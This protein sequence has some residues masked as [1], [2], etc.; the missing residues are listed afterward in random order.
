MALRALTERQLTVISTA[1]SGFQAIRSPGKRRFP[2]FR[3][4]DGRKTMSGLHDRLITSSWPN[5]PSIK[6]TTPEDGQMPIVSSPKAHD[7]RKCH[8]SPTI[9]TF[10]LKRLAGAKSY[11]T[12][13]TIP[14]HEFEDQSHPGAINVGNIAALAMEQ[15][16]ATQ[17]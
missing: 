7:W 13:S 16:W 5:V 17:P 15:R 12:S 1:R 6:S 11:M 4:V 2:D 9:D 10:S 3:E 8:C 14:M